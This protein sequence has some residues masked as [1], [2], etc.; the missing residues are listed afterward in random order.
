MKRVV[1]PAGTLE[2]LRFQPGQL[3]PGLHRVSGGWR[4]LEL[5]GALGL[6]LD[7]D[8]ACRHLVAVAHVPDLEADQVA[9][10][11]LAI[12]AEVEEGQFPNPVFYLQPDAQ[13]A[14]S[15]NLLNA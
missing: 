3:D 12:D 4:Y 1:D 5:N 7:D 15:Q 13:R 6:V 10:A 9:S 2:V 8:G 11:Q 14:M